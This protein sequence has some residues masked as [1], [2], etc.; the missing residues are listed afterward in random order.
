ADGLPDFAGGAVG[1]M[2][3]E[4]AG[5]QEPRSK[6]RLSTNGNDAAFMFFRTIVAFDHAK[7]VIKIVTLIFPDAEPQ[8]A[9]N[10]AEARNRTIREILESGRLVLPGERVSASPG[11]VISNFT[12][13][14]F[15]NAVRKA[16]ELIAAGEVYQVVLSQCFS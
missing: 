2:N 11:S 10:D 12:K 3:F 13:D 9:R 8:K 14:E 7:Q 5:W 6:A 16:K 1:I 4:C 15:E